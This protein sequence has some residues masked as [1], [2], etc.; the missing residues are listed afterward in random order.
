MYKDKLI[1]IHLF[2]AISIFIFFA[3]LS[4]CQQVNSESENKKSSNSEIEKAPITLI[5]HGGAGAIKRGYLTTEQEKDYKIKMTEALVTGYEVLAKGGKSIDAVMK[6]I[7]IM[8]NSPLFNA[9]KGAVLTHTGK[10]SMDAS[11]MQGNDLNAGAVAGVQHVKNPILAARL[12][13]DSSVHVM[14]SG[15]GADEYARVNG[16][17]MEDNAYFITAKRLR[18][19]KRAMGKDSILLESADKSDF[20][21]D[22][23]FG[24]VGCVA[25]DQYGNIAAGTSTGGMTN[26]KYGRIG[27]SPIIGAGT[28]ADNATCGVSCTGHGEYFIRLSIARNM[29]DLMAYKKLS[30][31][32]AA[33]EV[34]QNQL[35]MLGGTGG[36]VALDKNGNHVW[37]FNTPGMFR[38]LISEG[39]EVVVEFYE[40]D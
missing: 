1:F 9:G 8:E 28:Y 19:L 25:L 18:S 23:K 16:L 30:I 24:T 37:E 31:N 20:I 11:I 36:L 7:N 4:S 21:D 10:V 29:A 39:K 34:I 17:E 12:V 27:D 22:Y 2:S 3:F 26:K 33:E 38:G 14:L 32:E 15:S 13:M 40:N 6:T 35:T 5:I